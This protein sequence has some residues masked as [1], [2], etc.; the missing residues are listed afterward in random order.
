M[1]DRNNGVRDMNGFS[2]FALSGAILLIAGAACADV[3]PSDT[4]AAKSSS[5]IIALNSLP[6]PPTT[7]AT[8]KVVDAKG[9]PVG[10]VQKIV[11]DK[12]GK[13][14]T[15]DVSLM[16][17]GVVVAIDASRFN[18]DQGHNI[19]TATLDAQEIAAAPHTQG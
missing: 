2:Q 1:G 18:Y 10:G 7:L 15:V 16:G 13:P 4:S 11:M 5:G 3:T 17:T 12:A 8:A 14:E 6:N 9:T 19:L